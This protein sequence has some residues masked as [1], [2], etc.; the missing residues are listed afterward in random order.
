MKTHKILN[1]G[2]TKAEKN[3]THHTYGDQ[4]EYNEHQK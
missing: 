2:I 1:S 4:I 3:I